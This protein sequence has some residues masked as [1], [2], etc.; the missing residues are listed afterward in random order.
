MRFSVVTIC[1]N[2]EEEIVG[3]MESVLA[4]T[5]SGDFEYIVVDGASRDATM[6]RVRAMKRRF[7][8]KGIP[9]RA[10]SAPDKGIS[11]AFNKGV[12]YAQGE[13]VALVNA[14][15]ALTPDALKIISA[16]YR[17]EV[18]VYYG[19][20]WWEDE[21]KGVRY[22][23]KSEPTPRNLRTTMCI[24]HPS[25]FIRKS[26]YE[27]SGLYRTDFRYAMDRELLS[28]MMR[29]RRRFLY[30]DAE[31]SCMKAGGVSDSVAYTP[32]RK[33]E[34]KTIA[35]ACGVSRLRFEWIYN[36]AKYRYYLVSL[37]KRHPVLYSVL[38]RL[39]GR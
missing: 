34:S 15:D 31:F 19:N 27:A 7:M 1:Y 17:P 4:Q 30:L 21:A 39:K 9:F 16:A 20:I 38:L 12:E 35:L 33:W 26:A 25:C 2:A 32:Q 6:E 36:V 13:I 14:G 28:R 11:D 22:V 18:D 29:D 23:K 3:T 37:L 24:M 10:Y 8:D 5:Q